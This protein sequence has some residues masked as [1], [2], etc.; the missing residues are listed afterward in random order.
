MATNKHPSKNN[1]SIN[2][3]LRNKSSAKK[4]EQR[5]T[6]ETLR[7]ALL[8][9]QQDLAEYENMDS[10]EEIAVVVPRQF[11]HSNQSENTTD[12]FKPFTHISTGAE[13][14][15]MPRLDALEAIINELPD[16]NEEEAI[17][18]EAPLHTTQ[19]DEN[20][21]KQIIDFLI[22]ENPVTK[23]KKKT[24][25]SVQPSAKNDIIPLWELLSF[26]NRGHA[27][28]NIEKTMML[29]DI[30]RGL[31][32]RE[33]L[34]LYQPQWNLESGHLET[35]IS[36]LRWRHPKKGMLGSDFFIILFEEA[37]LI[38]DL[39]KILIEQILIDRT[40]L[41]LNGL[42]NIKMTIKLTPE[43]L[44]LD[45]LSDEILNLLQKMNINPSFIECELTERQF[46]KCPRQMQKNLQK[47]LEAG[48][49]LA[50][51]N[52]GT[53]FSA[54]PYLLEF[55]FNKIK[56][57]K[58]YISHIFQN[59]RGQLISRSVIYLAHLLQAKTVIDG[60][61]N[62]QIL[63]WLRMAGCDC[64]QGCYLGGPM[65]IEELIDFLKEYRTIAQNGIRE[66][67]KFWQRHAKHA[68]KLSPDC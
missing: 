60:I 58:S 55:P 65:P 46:L 6:N 66:I 57:D 35:V 15:T 12:N 43:Q 36:S 41:E 45:H 32:A 14:K 61:D 67:E 39:L 63:H 3:S 30:R 22:K 50:L 53:G 13:K 10:N 49:D 42:T 38:S 47:F 33:F 59:P 24:T 62:L 19:Y 27:M 48:I 4:T 21:M 23:S 25:V 29:A 8:E 2:Q 1:A 7:Q 16:G 52:F 17:R 34:Y 26:R 56:L 20:I 40:Q 11:D 9:T 18:E 68:E 37:G 51:D 54:Y 28:N 64:G 31:E 44:E 5:W